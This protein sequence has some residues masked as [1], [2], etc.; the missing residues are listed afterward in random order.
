MTTCHF[1]VNPERLRCFHLDNLVQILSPFQTERSL[2]ET[3]RHL[4]YL[5]AVIQ[6]LCRLFRHC[7]GED[8]SN[9]NSV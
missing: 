5:T 2:N 1:W 3:P 4:E 8:T 7:G 6:R 9:L